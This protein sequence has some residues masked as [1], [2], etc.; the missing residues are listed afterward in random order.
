M[1]RQNGDAK[2][3]GIHCH[4]P[5]TQRRMHRPWRRR[6]LPPTGTH[7][8][9]QICL[10][11]ASCHSSLGSRLSIMYQGG[12]YTATGPSLEHYAVPSTKRHPTIKLGT[13]A[14]L[15]ISTFE[16]KLRSIEPTCAKTRDHSHQPRAIQ[17]A[18]LTPPQPR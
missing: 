6:P 15:K 18:G 4:A 16:F 5:L 14:A 12:G 7:K 1:S 11:F 3:S 9:H 17:A 10:N 2:P 8:V 13:S